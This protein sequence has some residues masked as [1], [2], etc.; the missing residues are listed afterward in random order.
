LFSLES[1]DGAWLRLGRL[2]EHTISLRQG[3]A[4]HVDPDQRGPLWVIL[5]RAEGPACRLIS[6]LAPKRLNYH[7]PAK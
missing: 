6:G 5:D 2:P 1:A 3:A 4:P 7:A